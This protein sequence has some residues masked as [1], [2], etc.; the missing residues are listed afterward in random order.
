MEL[1]S[2]DEKE[3]AGLPALPASFLEMWWTSCLYYLYSELISQ[4]L[5]K[6]HSRVQVVSRWVVLVLGN[7]EVYIAQKTNVTQVIKKKKKKSTFRVGL[8]FFD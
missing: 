8:S 5:M 6:G 2:D 3:N 4:T 7:A 1:R